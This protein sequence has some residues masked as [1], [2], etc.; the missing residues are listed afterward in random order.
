MYCD[1]ECSF[2]QGPV[3]LLTRLA[4]SYILLFLLLLLWPNDFQ[5]E[6]CELK[7][8]WNGGAA[9]QYNDADFKVQ[10]KCLCFCHLQYIYIY[11][12]SYRPSPWVAGASFSGED[13]HQDPRLRWFSRRR[14]AGH[15]FLKTFRKILH[16]RPKAYQ[17]FDNINIQSFPEN[18]R[19]TNVQSI[20]SWLALGWRPSDSTTSCQVSFSLFKFNC[21]FTSRLASHCC[22][23]G[24]RFK[25]KVHS[26]LRCH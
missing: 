7:S 10:Y 14:P 19:M 11:D 24:P 5:G 12:A 13:C 6:Q 26:K 23:G 22:S 4:G 9:K 17:P 18:E 2:L 1:R 15:F 16:C 20:L 3:L 25:K 8:N 21:R